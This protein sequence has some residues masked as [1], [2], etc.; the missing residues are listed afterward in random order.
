MLIKPKKANEI[1]EKKCL[2]EIKHLKN[3]IA[4]LEQNF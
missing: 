2:I 1:E 4:L 3:R